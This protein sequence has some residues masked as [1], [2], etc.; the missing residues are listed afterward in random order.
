MFPSE[1][2]V[3]YRCPFYFYDFPST[4]CHAPFWYPPPPPP[5][6][7]LGTFMATGLQQVDKSSYSHHVPPHIVPTTPPLFVA[8]MNFCTGVL[9]PVSCALCL[10]RYTSPSCPSLS[11]PAVP[12]PLYPIVFDDSCTQGLNQ[13]HEIPIFPPSLSSN[14]S[15]PSNGG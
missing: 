15:L 1:D 8:V 14:S 13:N 9:S 6:F 2:D 3:C 5:P 10:M 4:I 12:P 11:T 7:A